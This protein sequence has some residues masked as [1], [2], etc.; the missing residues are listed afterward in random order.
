MSLTLGPPINS[1]DH[2]MNPLRLPKKCTAKDSIC[3]AYGTAIHQVSYLKQKNRSFASSLRPEIRQENIEMKDRTRAWRRKQARRIVIKIESTKTW[4]LNTVQKR[5]A[6][7]PA[8]L[9]AAK[10][11]KH[12][13]LT[14]MQ[15]IR[16]QLHLNHE[17]ADESAA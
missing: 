1:P 16:L 5:K 2:F 10:P 11:H 13:K 4:I 7:R 15:D 9:A 14:R 8:P 3:F 12:G 6:E 17:F